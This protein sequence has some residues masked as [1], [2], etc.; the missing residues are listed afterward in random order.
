MRKMKDS[1]VE[2]IGQIPE[3]WEVVKIKQVL[4]ERK[5]SN[6]P[7]KTSNILSLL[8]DRGVIPYEEKGNIGNK[9]KESLLDYKL[10][11]PDDIV[12]NSMNVIIGSVGLSKYFGAVS[13]VYYMLFRRHPED[14][15]EF[16]NYVFQSEQFQKSLIGYGNGILAH[17]MRIQMQKLNIVM[18]PFPFPNQQKR[19]VTYLDEKVAHIDNIIDKTKQTIEEYKKYKQSL[20]TEAVTKGLNPDV[21]MKDSGVEW[22]GEIPE[23]WEIRRG[24]VILKLLVRDVVE[25]DEIVTCFRDGEV[26]LRKNRRED[27][28]TNSLKEIGYQ[29]IEPGD[30][31]VHGM[32]GFAGAIGISDARGKGSPVLNVLDSRE[33]KKYFMYYLRT[34]AYRDVFMG[35][36]TGIRVRSCDLRWSKLAN[37]AYVVPPKIEQID[38]SNYLDEIGS[39]IEKAIAQKQSIV[40]E[41]ESYKKS[42]IY[43][44]VTG[45]R[46][47]S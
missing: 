16:F 30:L 2:W 22:I 20:I 28:F 24:K 1:G 40:A 35:L 7:I 41:L 29:G 5:E 25:T 11:Y 6:N 32:D 21:K 27:G 17:R 39:K 10:A 18:I 47:V 44:V 23:H 13:P 36:S 31:V 14:M 34:L 45:K 37:L 43:E 19:I 15:I 46:E 33:N 12:L 8:H 26:T 3:D 4:V 38:I 42:L 9:A